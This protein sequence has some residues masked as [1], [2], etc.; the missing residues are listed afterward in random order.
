MLELVNGAVKIVGQAQSLA[1]AIRP[2][3]V[4]RRLR[5]NSTDSGVR[6]L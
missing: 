4:V 1:S 2:S 6:S 3:A 5:V